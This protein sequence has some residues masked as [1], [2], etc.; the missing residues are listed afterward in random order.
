MDP[1]VRSANPGKCP[2]CG[3]K[4]R[5]G[6]PDAR[7]FEVTIRTT[8]ARLIPGRPLRLAFRVQDPESHKPVRDFDIVH[9]KL[10]HLFIV[11][12]DLGYF[13][14]EHPRIQPDGSF[15]LD[16]TFPTP[17]HY[18][19]LADFYPKGATPQLI[20]RSLIVPGPPPTADLKPDLAPR[21]SVNTEASLR[22]EPPQPIAGQKTMMFFR[23]APPDGLEPYLG[24]WGHMLAASADL[25]DL[26]HLHPAWEEKGPVVQFNAIFPRPGLYRVWVQF[27]R[28]GRVNTF[29]FTVPVSELK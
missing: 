7:E 6:L 18:R 24:A 2:R 12:E 14:H 20:A 27:Q 8:P 17:G 10:L 28:Q 9:E 13:A 21:K 22:L 3:M 4:L 26:L 1:E 19:L 5:P 25:I 15:L 23:L 11:R 29:A 16:T